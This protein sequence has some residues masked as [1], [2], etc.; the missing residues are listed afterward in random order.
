MDIVERQRRD[1]DLRKFCLNAFNV[2]LSEL[3]KDA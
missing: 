3:G 1:S 2:K